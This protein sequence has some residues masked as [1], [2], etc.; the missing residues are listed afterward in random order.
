MSESL[1]IG[2]V[3]SNVVW[4]Q[5]KITRERRETLNGHR[6]SVIWLTGLPG[7]GKSTV[8]SALEQSLHRSGCRSYV[9]DGDNVRHG[10]CGDLSFSEK[11][12]EEN[13]RRV[14]EVSRLF[15]DAGVIVIC[16]FVSSF[17]KDRERARALF[18]EGDFV[19]AYCNCPVEVC[20]RRDPKGHY[21]LARRGEIKEF[22]GISSPY[23]EP[24]NADLI[25]DTATRSVDECVEQ[26]CAL[27]R[28]RGILPALEARFQRSV[29]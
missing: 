9:L 27:L 2:N 23:Q 4:H 12:R 19:E 6:G 28:E 29:A 10:L 1:S 14:A 7:S 11:D 3:S 17:R 22:T 24:V 5:H 16:A 20:E 25:L 15:L 18:R 8:A 21:R 26:A 13:I